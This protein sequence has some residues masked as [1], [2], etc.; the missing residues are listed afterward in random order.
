MEKINE[1]K[2][3]VENLHTYDMHTRRNINTRINTWH[4]LAL[5]LVQPSVNGLGAWRPPCWILRLTAAFKGPLSW[6]PAWDRDGMGVKHETN[7]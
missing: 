4:H 2:D 6:Q 1:I 7:S 5:V 3:M